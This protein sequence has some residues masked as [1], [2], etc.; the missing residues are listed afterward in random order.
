MNTGREILEKI[1]NMEQDERSP[2][3]YGIY[4]NAK[5]SWTTRLNDYLIDR[6]KVR[7]KEK[8]YFFHMLAIMVDAGV[9]IVTGI[10]TLAYYTENPRFRRVLNTIAYHAERGV[11]LSDAMAS[12]DT[13]FDE[14]E[15]GIIKAGEATGKLDSI[16]LKLSQQ[17][18]KRH[19]MEMKVFSA[20]VYPIAVLSVL[21]LVSIGMLMWVLPTLLRLLEEGG[22]T[23]DKLPLATKVLLGIQ[24]VVIGYWWLILIAIFAAYAGFMSWKATERG[25]IRW[26]Y[27]KLKMPIIGKVLRKIYVLRFVGVMGLLID[28]GVYVMKSLQITGNA[29]PNKVYQAKAE[30][31]IE[32]VKNGGK[33]SESMSDTPF[34]FAPE[35]VQMIRVG[36]SSASLAQVSEKVSNQYQREVDNTLKKASSLF[37]P[38]LILIVGLFVALLALSIMAPIFSLTQTVNVA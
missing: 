25:A 36:E 23:M 32:R 37:E 1:R 7:L 24:S 10:K 28:S 21:V 4:D 31:I 12:F 18:D 8:S 35:V 27:F 26:D 38:I 20:S 19:D 14:A 11:I 34:L 17:L 2:V 15:I 30:E 13:I 22:L 16:L 5:A 33:I 29:V 9:P 3:I 6:S